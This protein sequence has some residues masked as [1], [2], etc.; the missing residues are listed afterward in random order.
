VGRPVGRGATHSIEELIRSV[1][2]G[3]GPL[4]IWIAR[5]LRAEGVSPMPGVAVQRMRMVFRRSPGKWTL[6]L[7][8][9]G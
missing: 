6:S 5:R 1:S 9:G 4:G 2:H 3:F 8:Y 7:A